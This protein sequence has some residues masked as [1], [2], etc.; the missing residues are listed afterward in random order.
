MTTEE[1]KA[2]VLEALREY[3]NEK[4]E[5]L[6]R[7]ESIKLLQEINARLGIYPEGSIGRQ[8]DQFNETGKWP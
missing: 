2:I 4:M 6:R 1:V 7:A 3:D 5:V 8:Y